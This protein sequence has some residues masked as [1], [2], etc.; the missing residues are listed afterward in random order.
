MNYVGLK[1]FHSGKFGEGIIMSQN[2]DGYI[3]VKFAS[4]P[5]ER[6][7]QAP[8]CFKGF[9]T[10]LD[11]N[12]A[13]GAV[14]ENRQ[15]D[16]KR[17][18]EELRRRRETQI[19]VYQR[20]KEKREESGKG[21]KAIPVPVYRSIGEFCN[22]QCQALNA[23]M[24]WVRQNGGK[25]VR[26]LEGELIESL[27]GK[28]VYSFETESELAVPDN[29]QISIW[30]SGATESIPGLLLNCVEFTVTIIT[31][32]YFGASVPVL[33]FSAD[34]WRLIQCLI[35]RL[36]EI[37][38][39]P[40]EITRELV[41]DGR[42]HITGGDIRTG[43]D[44]ACRMSLEQPVMFL[45]GPPGTGKTE[46]LAKITLAHMNKGMR[47][48]MLSYSNVSVDGAT[49]R[50]F[51]KMKEKK[52]GTIVRYGYPRDKELL[53]HEYL[54]SYNLAIRNSP[55][56][57]RE[58]DALIAER[59]KTSRTTPRWNEIGNRLTEIR[60]M[61]AAAEKQTVREASFVATTV[62]KALADRTVYEEEFDTV[63]F[64]EA[65]MAFIPQV[66]FAS[67]LVR[68]HFVCMGDFAQ[69][70][71]I[72]Q[73]DSNSVL[74]VDIFQY[75]GITDAVLSGQGH[76]WLCMLDVQYRMHPEIADFASMTMYRGLLRSGEGMKEKR[77]GIARANPF[78][79]H[80]FHMA[81]LSG[82]MSVCTKTADKSRINVLS[83]MISFGLAVRAAGKYEVGIITPYNA[84]SRL[85]YAMARDLAENAPTMN[86]ISCATVHQF[87][88]S[89]KDVIIYD[90]VDCY[91]M[92]YPGTLLTNTNN[93]YA[94]RLFN[95]AVTRAKG[96]MV[97]VANVDYMKTKGLS[98]GLIF[99]D[100]IDQL[101][102]AFSVARGKKL[103]EEVG[104][105]YLK[106][107]EPD[108]GQESFLT[109]LK[110]AAKSVQIDIPGSLF[111][112]PGF[113][114]ELGNVI[115]ELKEKGLKVIIRAEKKSLIP[116]E[117][118]P[119]TIENSFVA[120]PIAVID[121]KTVWF[122]MPLSNAVFTAEGKMIPT[123]C[124]PIIRF[125][126]THFATALNGFLEMNN[127]VDAYIPRE[128][129]S[130]DIIYN[131]FASYISGTQKC[132]ECGQPLRLKKAKSG[133]FFL[134]C[135]AYPRCNGTE[136]ITT[137]MVDNYLFLYNENG[138]LCP[139][140]HTTMVARK[141]KFGVY[142]SCSSGGTR[143]FQ[144]LDEI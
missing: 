126:G 122:G 134:S 2:A 78:A 60:K 67:S 91:R 73:N 107:F 44:T 68:Q 10:L 24:A 11:Q 124:R 47:V 74:N 89:E 41:C 79:K 26:I 45:W 101:S 105:R 6:E 99:R 119:Y 77:Q 112:C 51:S 143:H 109:D 25:R 137:E 92:P 138:R 141:N 97:P 38:Q 17:Q 128:T 50:V 133:R 48:L 63:I 27:K 114:K 23:E 9:L 15:Q 31:E 34:P 32:H 14:E 16:E 4:E 118:L 132:K 54:S 76:D 123:T 80:V 111:N 98:K 135:S 116:R 12:A 35:D 120:N 125:E 115:E 121:K 58:R 33:E 61:M 22:D 40:S 46:T 37:R 72:V 21:T 139:H 130:P 75:C 127:T 1:V 36:Q 93:N 82:T 49:R 13:L 56:L 103:I 113:F 83:A 110:S 85:L 94:N 131:T 102:S 106:T 5:T 71:P 65:S 88:G 39:K 42:L 140:D 129:D 18:S 66:I 29:T 53:N 55:D 20:Q 84:Q 43:Q 117:I 87:Q 81:D 52:P 57:L 3:R 59:R 95:V 136:E 70:P 104:S 28:Y 86:K 62:S 8:G 69:L 108:E 7:F 100:L 30:E 144:K 142:L 64:D 90:A 96:K 19:R